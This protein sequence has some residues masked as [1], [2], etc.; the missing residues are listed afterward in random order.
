MHEK[1]LTVLLPVCAAVV[2]ALVIGLRMIVLSH[3][4]DNAA[5]G[6]PQDSDTGAN[7]ASKHDIAQDIREGK[8]AAL[9][10]GEP[11]CLK[12]LDKDLPQATAGPRLDYA[13]EQRVE[14][15]VNYTKAKMFLDKHGISVPEKEISAQIEHYKETPTDISCDC[16]HTESLGEHLELHFMSLDELGRIIETEKGIDVY[17]ERKWQAE[18]SAYS[19]GFSDKDVAD[20]S[21]RYAEK[22]KEKTAEKDRTKILERK[23]KEEKKKEILSEIQNTVIPVEKFLKKE[24]I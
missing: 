9:I 3:I 10:N 6:K 22:H 7:T 20:I 21:R 17:L 16:C 14:R 13:R 5:K 1:K 23:F 4:N 24:K 8:V 15:L 2:I 11:V 12:D 18:R 19:A